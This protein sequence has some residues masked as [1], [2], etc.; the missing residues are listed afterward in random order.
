GVWQASGAIADVNVLLAGV[1]YVP[2]ANYNATF[3]IGTSIDDRS[4]ERRVGKEGRTRRPADD[5][6]KRTK[7]NGA[8]S[9]NRDNT[10]H[11]VYNVDSDV[12]NTTTTVK[13]TLSDINARTLTEDAQS[14]ESRRVHPRSGVWQASGAIADVNVLLAGVSYV[15]A[16]NYNATFSIGTSIDD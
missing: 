14:L 5:E 6:E 15:P 7:R 4:E 3:S 13:L 8:W 2:A 1:S 9:H 16:A 11:P 12:D 10:V